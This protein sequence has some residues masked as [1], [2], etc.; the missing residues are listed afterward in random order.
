MQ[1]LGI[2]EDAG[3]KAQRKVPD[4]QQGVRLLVGHIG[5]RDWGVHT[6]GPGK[7]DD[8]HL[9]IIEIGRLKVGRRLEDIAKGKVSWRTQRRC[10]TWSGGRKKGHV[11]VLGDVPN[12]FDGTGKGLTDDDG[13]R[14]EEC[15]DGTR[16]GHQIRASSGIGGILTDEICPIHTA[17]GAV[18]YGAEG[19]GT[20][21]FQIHRLSKGHRAKAQRTGRY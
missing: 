13:P 19:G 12:P 9:A 5:E 1:V 18:G 15:R 17:N 8:S 7:N 20:G 16:K 11:Q 2:R 6:S 4:G 10:N 21:N 3:E 14:A